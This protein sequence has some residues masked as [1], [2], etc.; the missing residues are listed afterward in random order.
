MAERVGLAEVEIQRRE[1]VSS[2]LI[3][4]LSRLILPKSSRFFR[5]MRPKM[6][7]SGVMKAI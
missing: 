3:T 4:F 7:A 2:S 5:Y 6:M 1:S